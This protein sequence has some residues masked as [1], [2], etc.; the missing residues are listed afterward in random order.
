M[1]ARVMLAKPRDP[2][3]KGRVERANGYLRSSFEP[4]RQ[5]ATIEDF[6][7]QLDEWVDQ[8]ANRRLVRATSVRLV[9]VLDDERLG[10]TSLPTDMPPATIHTTIRVARD[11]HVR[12]AGCDYSIDPTMIG[13]MVEVDASWTR[14]WATCDHHLVADHPRCVIPHHT[15]T[16]PAHVAQAAVLRAR[17]QDATR[18]HAS[19]PGRPLVVV[20]DRDLAFYDQLW[21]PEATR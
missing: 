21:K 20:E 15:I 2:E 8:K 3:T 6:N 12:V 13:R 16:D 11:Y 1:G 9:D 7:T 17:Y 18:V 4:A 14:V 10:L 19:R 5:F